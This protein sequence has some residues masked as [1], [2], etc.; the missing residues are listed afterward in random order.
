MLCILLN[1]IES[2]GSL[3]N[4]NYGLKMSESQQMAINE[5]FLSQ[6]NFAGSPKRVCGA[7]EGTRTPADLR[8]RA[9]KARALTA[10][11]PR[12][13][14]RFTSSTE[15]YLKIFTDRVL[16]QTQ[17]GGVSEA[18]SLLGKRKEKVGL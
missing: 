3:E 12:L 6:S 1:K 16:A 4:A 11:P 5:I 7:E 17:K 8:P 14:C 15:R 9:L 13:R 10:L 18:L 2:Q